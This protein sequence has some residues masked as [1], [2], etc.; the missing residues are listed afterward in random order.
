M[1]SFKTFS[2]RTQIYILAAAAAIMLVALLT[3]S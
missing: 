3:C 1:T 2:L